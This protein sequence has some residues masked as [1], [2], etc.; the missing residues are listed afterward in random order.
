LKLATMDLIHFAIVFLVIFAN[1]TLGGF[2]LF[3]EQ[4]PEWSQLGRAVHS[5]F[6]MTL[7]NFKY[8]RLHSV[9]PI[10]AGIWFWVYVVL[11][12]FVLVN[13]LIAIIMDHYLNVKQRI[14]KVGLGIWSQVV[15]MIDDFRWAHSYEGS[16]KSVPIDQLLVAMTGDTTLAHH[17]SVI[18]FKMDRRV[19]TAEDILRIHTEPQVTVDFLIENGCDLA[20]AKRLIVKCQQSM[21]EDL[22][23]DN[24]LDQ[25]NMLVQVETY[26]LKERAVKLENKVDKVLSRLDDNL[27][28]I[29]LKQK[30]C[31]GL[32]KRIETA[33]KLPAGWRE[34]VDENG[35]KFYYHEKSGQSFGTLPRSGAGGDIPL[36][37][38][39][40]SQP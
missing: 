7:G 5:T 36:S 17:R 35:Q 10:S 4:L 14:G 28:R 38:T 33:Q 30:K 3:G 13:L 22:R 23:D 6:E 31:I 26:K 1:F 11:G 19:R 37:N 21:V 29:D 25:L 39:L 40:P 27:D 16:R 32:A 8:S 15:E 24:P 2:V 9:A 34:I 12:L 18:G 20:S